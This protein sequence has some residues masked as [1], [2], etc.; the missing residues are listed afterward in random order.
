ME[1]PTSWKGHSFTLLVFT[2]IVVLCAIFFTLG[3][4][5]GRAQGQKMAAVAAVEAAAKSEIRNA[6]KEEKPDLTFFDSVE[7]EKE[8][9]AL[10]PRPPVERESVP[11]SAEP[12]KAGAEP[13]PPANV[14]NFQIA[15]LKKSSEA[16]KLLDSVK[17]KG[18]RAFILSPPATDANPYFRVQV[19]PF[20]NAVEAEDARRKLEAA[21]FQPILK[22]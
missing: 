16:E 9:P 12:P 3:M 14:I 22:K 2:G 15:A 1:D 5:V 4:L 6:P 7:N 20:A 17:E 13:A 10:E 8:A 11:S 21:G 19:G 18:F